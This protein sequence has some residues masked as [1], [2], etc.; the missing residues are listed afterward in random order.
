MKEKQLDLR[1]IIACLFISIRPAQKYTY[2]ASA[3]EKHIL[4]GE[5]F[6]Q[7][8]YGSFLAFKKHFPF[9]KMEEAIFFPVRKS[10][11]TPFFLLCFGEMFTNFLD[12]Q[13][14]LFAFKEEEVVVVEGE[15]GIMAFDDEEGHEEFEFPV[16]SDLM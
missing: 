8:G 11:N 7:S 15:V 10:S 12:V 14:L 1:L 16:I 6:A 9:K 4:A 5:T 3:T 2:L 13:V